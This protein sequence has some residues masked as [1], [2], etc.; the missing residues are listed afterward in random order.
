MAKDRIYLGGFHAFPKKDNVPDF[1]IGKGSINLRELK[2]WL[3]SEEAEHCTTT[4]NSDPT[5]VIE[6]VRRKDGKTTC[7]I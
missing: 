5:I 7:Y 4:Y 1:V 3:N 2:E 6:I